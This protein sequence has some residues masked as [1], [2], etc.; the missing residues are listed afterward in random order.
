[1]AQR[2]DLNDEWFFAKRFEEELITQKYA[3]GGMERIRLPHTVVT[4][5]YNYFDESVYQMVSGYRRHLQIPAKWKGKRLRLTFEGAAHDSTVYLNGE[6]VAKHHCGY[7][8]F[9]V[10]V[11]D[12]LRYGEDNILAVRLD[13]RETLNTPP[14]GY[15]IDYM[16]YGG[17][18]RGVYLEVSE[19]V[20]IRDV[21]LQTKGEIEEPKLYTEVEVEG[22]GELPLML[23]QFWVHSETDQELICEQSYEQAQSGLLC[24]SVQMTGVT[25][26][27]LSCPTL[28]CFRTQ[29]L[30][31]QTKELYDEK[32]VRFGF[33]FSEFRSD[34]YYLNGEKVKI[35]GLNRHQ[36]YP[37]VGYAMPDSMQRED[38]R[39]LK[40]ELGVNAVRTSHYPQS[41][42]FID[43]CDELGLLVFT[44]IPG[45]QHIGDDFWKDQAVHNTEDMVLQYRNH[46]SIILWGV[47]IN[48]SQDDDA[49]YERTNE[50]AH[51]LDP[52]RQTGGVRYLKKSHL[53]EDVYTYNDFQHDGKAAGCARK[54]D[55]TP[56]PSKPYLI[57]EYNGHM[58]PTKSFDAE[59]HRR[60]HAIRHANVLDAVAGWKDIAGSFGWCMFDYNTHKDF[61]SGDRICYHG[62]LDMFRNPKL[63]SLVYACEQEQTPVLDISSSMDI[64]EHPAS[65]RGAI[66]IFSNA[67]SVRMYKNDRFLK[68]YFP[69]DS[70]YKHLKHG[71]ILVDDFIGNALEEG[72]NFKPAQAAAIKEMLNQTALR[73]MSDLPKRVYL[74]GA[75]LILLYHMKFT[76]AV[77]LYNKYVGD[78]GGASTVYRFEAIKDG[79]VVKTI[80][81]APTTRPHLKAIADHQQL[82]EEATYDVAA[83]RLQMVDENENLL[84]FYQEPV[85]LQAEGPIELIG[86]SVIS[87]KGGMGGT[88]VRTTGGSGVATLTVTNSEGERIKVTF[89]VKLHRTPSI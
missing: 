1:M 4:T 78:W 85:T 69:K 83:I 26:W 20:Y 66:W 70:P 86:P 23:R 14:F 28:Y 21:F 18:Y 55:I 51:R 59:E 60:E 16:T 72:A 52:T 68:E 79:K 58:F 10:D 29:L 40:E 53:L 57:S 17:I 48:E 76:D 12:Q 31:A 62:V 75:K 67:D 27:S 82:T 19:T 47:R 13:S 38:A 45:W 42:A 61:G 30:N 9:T 64:G 56:D 24:A 5:P 80:V 8:A 73:G 50:V 15:V 25:L 89:L 35:R 63:A 74:L 49:L 36:S 3:E 37:Y 2:F 43:A 6:M 41:H 46:P 87:L 88:Y 77:T 22:A 39:I 84:S 33:R 44:E 54:S 7:T 34:G 71:P 11:T 65:N 81:K 32:D